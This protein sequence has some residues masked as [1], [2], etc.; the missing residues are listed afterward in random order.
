MLGRMLIQQVSARREWTLNASGSPHLR[1]FLWKRLIST[2]QGFTHGRNLAHMLS[3][4]GKP[5][6]CSPIYVNIVDQSTSKRSDGAQT[7]NNR[8]LTKSFNEVS[9]NKCAL[10]EPS[11]HWKISKQPDDS[12]SSESKCRLSTVLSLMW[13]LEIRPPAPH[14]TLAWLLAPASFL[15]SDQFSFTSAP[16]WRIQRTLGYNISL[17]AKLRG[18]N[19]SQEPLA[20]KPCKS[21]W[22]RAEIKAAHAQGGKLLKQGIHQYEAVLSHRGRRRWQEGATTSCPCSL[23][24]GHIETWDITT[25]KSGNIKGL[26]HPHR[27]Y[28]RD[29]GNFEAGGWFIY[30]VQNL[31]AVKILRCRTKVCWF[32]RLASNHLPTA[33][34]LKQNTFICCVS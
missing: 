18:P 34:S 15:R 8:C 10:E 22:H 27:L 26:A 30:T 2:S 16:G 6:C 4:T 21:Q 19:Y 12:D 24:W 20:P 29:S 28:D 33:R 31:M 13:F 32:Q 1:F 23:Q 3:T 11:H 5:A 14:I 25:R 7:L 17:D 9:D